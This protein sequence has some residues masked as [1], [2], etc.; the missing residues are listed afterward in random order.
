MIPKV[1]KAPLVY[2][3][4][5]A[6]AQTVE[7]SFPKI[8]V[9]AVP[10]PQLLPVLLPTTPVEEFNVNIC[11]DTVLAMRVYPV[12]GVVDAPGSVYIVTPVA[13][14]ELEY[15]I[16]EESPHMRYSVLSKRKLPL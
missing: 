4:V 5:V 12:T 7:T 13:N 9:P 10:V 1:A 15:K 2:R 6:P 11:P 8:Y 14:G 16:T 3:V